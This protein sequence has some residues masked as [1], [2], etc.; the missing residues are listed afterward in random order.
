M[1]VYLDYQMW[2]YINKNDRV[3]NF[4]E[5]KKEENEWRYFISVAHLEEL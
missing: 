5:K 4:F 3:K 2:D 1:K